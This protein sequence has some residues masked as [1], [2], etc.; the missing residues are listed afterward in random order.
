MEYNNEHRASTIIAAVHIMENSKAELSEQVVTSI[1][2][3]SVED[4]TYVAQQIIKALKDLH[5]KSKA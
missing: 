3:L 4:Q 2:V 1:S 5:L